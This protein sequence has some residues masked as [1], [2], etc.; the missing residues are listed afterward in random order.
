MR[1]G[2][3][4]IPFARAQAALNAGQLGFAGRL[5]A[6]LDERSPAQGDR[7]EVEG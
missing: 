1:S 7:R 6:R 4:Y 3:P 2:L 5:L